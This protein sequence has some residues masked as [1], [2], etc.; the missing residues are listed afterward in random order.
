MLD[1]LNN[2]WSAKEV[3]LTIFEDE[4]HVDIW[5]RVYKQ[6]EKQEKSS[7]VGNLRKAVASLEW[8]MKKVVRIRSDGGLH[9]KMMILEGSQQRRNMTLFVF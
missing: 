3:L 7:K 2:Q 6:R 9:S 4:S 8:A 5:E 1:F